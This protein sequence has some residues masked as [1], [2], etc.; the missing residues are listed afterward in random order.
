MD[1][2]RL[3]GPIT[4]SLIVNYADKRVK[5]DQIVTI[6]ER[7]E[8]LIDRY[9]KTEQHRVRLREKLGEYLVLERRIFEHLAIS[10]IE[11]E[12]MNLSLGE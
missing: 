3:Y 8:D 12:L 2:I 5:H 4:E 10:P 6:Q 7:F 11:A 9:A 1:A